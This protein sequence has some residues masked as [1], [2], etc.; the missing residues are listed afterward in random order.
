MLNVLN[1]W[2]SFNCMV[3]NHDKSQIVHFRPNCRNWTTI[4]FTCGDYNLQVV[5]KYMYLGI[6]LDEHLDCG[7]TA[8]CVVQSAGRA[9]GL[10][11]A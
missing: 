6:L 5:N 9:L 4:S 8:K 10:L 1:T 11:I 7:A 2:C 3:V